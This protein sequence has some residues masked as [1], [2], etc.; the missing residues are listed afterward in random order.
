MRSHDIRDYA[1]TFGAEFFVLVAG[2]LSLRLAAREFGTDGFG[3]YVLGRRSL[4]LLQLPATCGMA[5]GLTRFLA[6]HAGDR[7]RRSGY[8]RAGVMIALSTT[9]LCFALLLASVRHGAALLFGDASD[10]VLLRALGVAMVGLVVHSI[11]YGVARGRL[12]MLVANGLQVV[13]LG[14]LPLAA[15]S[16]PGISV[17][18]LFVVLGLGWSVFGGVTLAAFHAAHRA[19]PA[20]RDR[21]AAR[22][23]LRFGVAR[24]PGEL[25]LGALA[26][27]PV[28]LAAHVGGASAAGYLGIMTSLVTMIVSAFAPLGQL[29]LPQ[30]A[31]MAG[32]EEY[33]AIRRHARRATL[34]CVSLAALVVLLLEVTM[35]VIVSGYF[36]HAFLPAVPYARV[37]IIA[38]IPYTAYVVLRNVLDAL[39]IRALNAKNL[40][41]GVGVLLIA[42]AVRPSLIA[43]PIAYLTACT[44]VGVLSILDARRLMA[45]VS[46]R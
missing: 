26:L 2:L 3:V 40:I 22:T 34:L 21:E 30:I 41:A 15:L 42:F 36:G 19:G 46:A 4:A 17:S 43:L 9:A 29:L 5:I 23:L 18:T 33:G 10:V 12:R 27:L 35:G 25:A 16:V 20:L 39:E 24:I 38:A 31:T 45:R 7:A 1:A 8:F 28:N 14:L 37:G 6:L 11:A 13:S 44:A 32:R